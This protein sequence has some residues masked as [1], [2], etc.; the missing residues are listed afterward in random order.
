[1]I[2]QKM[3]KKKTN[4][5]EAT[6]EFTATLRVQLRAMILMSCK[7]RNTLMEWKHIIKD[8]LV[9]LRGSKEREQQQRRRS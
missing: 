3:L 9:K 4:I 2:R 1:M 8:A 6:P 5:K 7:K